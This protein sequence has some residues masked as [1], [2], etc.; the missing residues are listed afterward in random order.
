LALAVL[1]AGVDPE[2]EAAIRKILKDVDI[3][4]REANGRYQVFL[5]GEDVSDKI[6]TPQLS[7]IASK[8]SALR[9]VRERMVEL[10]R[11]LGA[12]G[13]VVAEGRDIGTVVFPE[14]EVKIYLDAAPEERARRR[15]EEI[16]SQGGKATLEETVR[17]MHERDRRDQER[18]IA[19]LRK[20][21]DAVVIDSTALGIDRVV[22][23]IRE[24]IRM[25]MSATC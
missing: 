24:E 23:E 15:A 12:Y 5:N 21:E 25:K 11:A 2:D 9:A 17:E 8:V 14:A 13:G 10:Q 20:A 3:Q 22:D 1:R 19:P 7:Q 18:A 16:A 4:L 6:R